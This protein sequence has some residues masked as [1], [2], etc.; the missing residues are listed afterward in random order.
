MN[1]RTFKTGDRI[2]IIAIAL[3]V[4]LFIAVNVWEAKPG[5]E[6]IAVISQDNK[7]IRQIDLNNLEEPE[8]IELSN[9][10]INQVILVEK[11][12]IRFWQSD[13]PDQTCVETAWLTKTGDKAVCL[14][15]KTVITI[16]GENNQVDVFSY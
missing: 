3:I 6:L 8:Y 5:E 2:L 4:V 15:A 9:A 10:G 11:G 13:C 7:L 12:K 14:P 16:Q 1:I